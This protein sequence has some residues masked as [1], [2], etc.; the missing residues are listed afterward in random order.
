M[1]EKK[2]KGGG[3]TTQ[4][5]WEVVEASNDGEGKEKRGVSGNEKGKRW[6]GG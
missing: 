5:T 3:G 6:M 1:G 2:R 4:V